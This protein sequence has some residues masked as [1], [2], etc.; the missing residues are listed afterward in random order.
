MSPETDSK[1]VKVI[2]HERGTRYL[3]LVNQV[4]NG[5]LAMDIGAENYAPILDKIGLEIVNRSAEVVFTP[6]SKF[7]MK[8]APDT[9]EAMS[10]TL[11]K[12]SGLKIALKPD[13]YRIVA[14]KNGVK[15]ILEITD[16]KIVSGIQPGDWVEVNSQPSTV[17]PAN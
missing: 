2:T 10:A 5:S 3:D 8:R 9:R 12:A 15:N 7:V 13:Q 4:G 16:A 14:N 17:L 1:G 6:N 11:V